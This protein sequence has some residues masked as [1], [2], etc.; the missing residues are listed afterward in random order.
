M[1]GVGVT[2]HYPS[3]GGGGPCG[4][5]SSVPPGPLRLRRRTLCRA[6]AFHGL[7]GAPRRI[8][9]P[10][11]APSGAGVSAI[12]LSG[13]GGWRC[14][15]PR[16]EAPLVGPGCLAA[17]VPEGCPPRRHDDIL[18]WHGNPGSAVY[19]RSAVGPCKRQFRGGAHTP[20]FP[21]SRGCAQRARGPPGASRAPQGLPAPSRGLQ[22]L[23]GLQ[24]SGRPRGS[25]GS[26]APARGLQGSPG[27]PPGLPAPSSPLQGPPGLPKGL[28]G[29]QGLP[30]PSSP[31]QG[32][33]GSSP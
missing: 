23:Q 25:Q 4:S 12:R 30:A 7:S 24:G 28:Q 5:P 26:P 22:G 2:P 1:A 11:C 20:R 33:Q 6:V 18:W 10:R 16:R 3:L 19:T 27:A 21:P 13:C 29:L 31:L 9:G 8:G 32:L 17:A 15:P 14:A